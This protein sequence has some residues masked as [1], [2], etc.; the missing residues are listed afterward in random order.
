MKL[1][2][3]DLRQIDELYVQHLSDHEARELCVRLLADL[4]EARE[5]L[6]QTPKNSSRP[7]SSLAP[8]ESA[9]S[10]R[11]ESEEEEP[12]AGERAG[13]DGAP[14]ADAG[15]A[16]A[17]AK[18]DAKAPPSTTEKSESS[19]RRAGKQPGAPGF[20]RTQQFSAERTEIHRPAHCHG[21]ARALSATEAGVEYTGYQ[22][23]DLRPG[24]CDAPGLRLHVVDHRYLEVTCTCGHQSRAAPHRCASA[25]D[26]R[27]ILSEWRLIGPGLAALIV[28]LSLRHR[29]SRAQIREWLQDWLGLALSIGVIDQTLRETAAAV[30]PLEQ[31]LIDELQ[32]TPVLHADETSWPEQG[33]RSLWL[34]VFLTT[35]TT[36]YVI[37][38]RGKATVRRIL[39]HFSGHLMSDGWFSY[40]DDPQRLRC[41]AHL[42]RKAQG[43]IDG[44][45]ADARAFGSL[46]NEALE[47]L[48]EAVYAAR[49][50][51]PQQ[52]P[53]A[54]LQ[55]HAKVLAALKQ[56]CR[57]RL[58]HAHGKTQQLAVELL[59]DWEAIF[60][61]LEHPHLPLTNNT[62]ERALRHWVIARRISHGTRNPVGSKTF[63]LLASVIETCRQRQ[64]SPWA[65][66]TEA[67]TQR[68]AGLALPPLPQVGV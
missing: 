19:P 56:A 12:R 29:L 25:L 53:G 48:M 15:E 30:E 13:D 11:P 31:T 34:W 35:T 26:E 63:T 33:R 50:G 54:L 60:R 18:E 17:A 32:D 5:R 65:Y 23:I 8:W 64:H 9:G 7:P 61:V 57:L 37:A 40:R 16:D 41:W 24:G 68:R 44:Y 58:G 39:E 28:A 36:F 38:G 66:L 27:V 3:H 43:L 42:L 22:T 55:Q 1:T 49:E 21:C 4:K 52:P 20:G 45:D 14:E 67:I 62:A 47:D 2:A 51:P 6:E 59:N 10:E 46:V